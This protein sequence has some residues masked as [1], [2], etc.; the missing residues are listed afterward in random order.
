MLK[1]PSFEFERDVLK[2]IMAQEAG[3]TVNKLVFVSKP[4][5]SK[6]HQQARSGANACLA[7]RDYGKHVMD[8]FLHRDSRVSEPR[9]R[10]PDAAGRQRESRSPGSAMTFSISAASMG[11]I[12]DRTS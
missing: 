6:R 1:N 2:A 10:T 8:P 9:R 12:L 5:A 11:R 7:E 4:V 3:C